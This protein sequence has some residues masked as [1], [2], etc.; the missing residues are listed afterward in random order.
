[1][2][3][4]PAVRSASRSP[5]WIHLVGLC[6][7]A[8]LVLAPSPSS[9]DARVSPQGRTAG[10]V[11]LQA[12][13]VVGL[14]AAP[15]WAR[16][17]ELAAAG[18]L[19]LAGGL[20]A[21]GFLRQRR[22]RR[23]AETSL[24]DR[25]R[26]ES[27]LAKISPGLLHVA[28]EELDGAIARELRQVAKF[29]G[30]DRVALHE[31][32]PSRAPGRIAWAGEGIDPLPAALEPGR[33]PWTIE[34]L[35]RDGDV[36]FSRLHDLPVAAASDRESYAAAGTRSCLARPLRHGGPILGALFLESVRA[37]RACPD[38]TGLD[39]VGRLG[40]ALAGVL[41]RKRAELALAERLRFEVLLSAQSAA[42]S[43][44]SAAD[45]DRE[46]DDALR[47]TVEF[48]G[49]DRGSLAEFTPE[50]G[51]AR[52]T[53]GWARPGVAPPPA[54]IDLTTVPWAERRL[55]AGEVVSF[56]R[57]DDLPERDAEVDRRTY[58]HLGVASHI[59]VPLVGRGAVGGALVFSTMRGERAWPD[60]LAQ[61]LR[62]LAEVFASI[63]S[64]R[65]ADAEVRRLRDE[66]AHVG[67][68]S[69]VGELT[70]SLAH[71]LGQ[72]LTAILSNAEAAQRLLES[73]RAD[74]DEVQAILQDIVADDQRACEVISRLRG[75]LKRG[76]LARAALDLNEVT[77]E[78]ARLV[79]G[80]AVARGVSIR[81][82]LASALPPVP[83]DRVELQ[84]V[85][86]NLIL[87]GLDAMRQTVAAERVLVLQTL[88]DGVCGVRVIVRDAG[89]GIDPDS[90]N[91]VFE[92][93]HTTKPAGL[94][95]GLAIARSIVEAHGGRLLAENNPGRGATFT[96]ALPGAV[97]AT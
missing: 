44:A 49:V 80:D 14:D 91:R 37:E 26:F 77:R 20:F 84:Q 35:G 73:D 45:L 48:L 43:R 72:P 10:D 82:E 83:G 66:L 42:F 63:L 36:Q 7:V 61:R 28:P 38:A 51:T 6:T 41:E 62:L 8:I 85:L 23:R 12:G 93:F 15:D 87:N 56:S 70:A 47:R 94:G 60:E 95:M 55:R 40:E 65:R 89:S 59:E 30:V 9:L 58:A 34:Q 96:F 92:A 17:W 71:E 27:L 32:L 11:R 1:M 4:P 97:G 31:Y 53:H 74:L 67:R 57:V 13:R 54:T 50:G 39:R 5:S 3:P 19:A 24:A 46:I 16:R 52:T 25:T 29:F 22:G 69:T 88:P 76:P 64:R 33:L 75:L 90:L 68:V 81:L 2:K 21:I 79:R 86:L 78:V 18:A